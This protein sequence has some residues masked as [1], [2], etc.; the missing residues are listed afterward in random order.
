MSYKR[1]PPLYSGD[2]AIWAGE[3]TRYL[4]DV[5]FEAEGLTPKS[6]LLE[7][8]ITTGAISRATVDGV[9]M[10]R[11]DD[12]SVVYSLNGAWVA[13]STGDSSGAVL[14]APQTED[15]S[16][17]TSQNKDNILFTLIGE[18]DQIGDLTQFRETNGSLLSRFDALG[19]PQNMIIDGGI[20]T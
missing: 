14:R 8:Q 18:T 12:N 20:D 11:V 6:I 15:E 2:P 5:A 3:L 4:E 16:T 17:I 9:L 7:H 19:N 13:L 1:R 10:Y